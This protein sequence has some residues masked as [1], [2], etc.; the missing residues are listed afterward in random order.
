MHIFT[1]AVIV[2]R[3]NTFNDAA[4]DGNDAAEDGN[5]DGG[6]APGEPRVANGVLTVHAR[7]D[8]PVTIFDAAYRKIGLLLEDDSFLR[9]RDKMREQAGKLTCCI[10]RLCVE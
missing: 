10:Q 3:L 8:V 9:F 5:G 1:E 4:E 7:D 6:H 2:D